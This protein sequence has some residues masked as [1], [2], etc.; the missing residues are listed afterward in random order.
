MQL[1]NKQ[2]D[3]C[4][5]LAEKSR[6][7]QETQWAMGNVESLE[8]KFSPFYDENWR[9]NCFCQKVIQDTARLNGVPL[10]EAKILVFLNSVKRQ[11]SKIYRLTSK[12]PKNEFF[13][14]INS[15]KNNFS[16]TVSLEYY[17]S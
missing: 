8:K 11:D 12:K 4:K 5:L 14:A 16:A 9:Q 1:S 2:M 7:I 6:Q 10:I 17:K 13:I 15:P 3:H